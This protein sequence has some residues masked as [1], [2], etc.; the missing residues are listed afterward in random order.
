[1]L[2]QSYGVSDL[3]RLITFDDYKKYERFGE[4]R[5]NT[6]A[7]ITDIASTINSDDYQISSIAKIQDN[8]NQIFSLTNVEDD[9]ALRKIND[10]IKRFYKVKQADRNLIVNQII[11]LLQ[12]AIPMSIIKLDLKQF[13]ESIDRNWILDKLKDDALLSVN[14]IRI[15]EHFFSLSDFSGFTG[16]PRGIGI[17]A[18]LSELY[19]RDFDR[20]V[21]RL[22]NVYFY[23]RYVD[24]IILFTTESPKAIIEKIKQNGLL[25]KPLVFN[26]KKTKIFEV[27]N[28]TGENDKNLQFE[29]LGYRFV[30]SD[31][32]KKSKSEFKDKKIIVSIASRKVKKYKT[33]IVHSFLDFLKNN[34]F[35]LLE[36]RLKFLTGNYPIKRNPS[37]GTTL[38]AGLYYNY[39]FI[40]D[41]A[42][43]IELTVFLRK[44]INS[45]SKSLG[46]KINAAF[47]NDQK[48][49]LS[50]YSFL[51]GWKNRKVNTDF[52]PERVKQIK[53]CWY[54][55]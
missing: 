24:D 32:C 20:K 18:T 26:D 6:L 35:S 21:N 44:L 49:Q 16:L 31:S 38:Y 13:Y 52:R 3:L 11:V 42:I 22:D 43:L 1:M 48:E 36:D 50:I 41:E 10:T 51:A 9:F 53:Q 23:A 28:T 47:S 12:E 33:R 37:E 45:K 34:D 15:L 27:D 19:L 29:Y 30:F 7:I 39:P 5:Q 46:I 55:G 17:S 2:N 25:R 54:N 4:S 8:E 14:A 40:N